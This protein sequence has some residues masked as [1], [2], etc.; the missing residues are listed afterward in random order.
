MEKQ[1]HKKEEII[2]GS[3]TVSIAQFKEV[4][5]WM[6]IDEIIEIMPKVIE[7]LPNYAKK[8]WFY[9]KYTHFHNLSYTTKHLNDSDSWYYIKYYDMKWFNGSNEKEVFEKMCVRLLRKSFLTNY[10]LRD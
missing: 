2:W 5:D 9:W 10:K 3:Q 1:E 8:E 6:T 4:L 7:W